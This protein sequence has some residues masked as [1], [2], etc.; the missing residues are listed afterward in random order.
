MPAALVTGSARGIG[1]ALVLE[2]A[3]LGYDV[4]IHYRSSAKEAQE[5]AEQAAKYGVKALPLQADVSSFEEAKGLVI[6]AHNRLGRLDVLVN[7]VG[8]YHKAPLSEVSV[9]NWHAMFDSNLHPVFYTCQTAIPLMRAQGK[10]RI[11]NIGFAG[12][13]HLVARPVITAYGIAKTG[14]ILYSKALAKSEA[15]NNITIN[16]ISPG[17]MEN[18]ETKP[19]ADIPIARTG[20][21]SELTAAVKFLVSDEAA[22]ITGV[23]LEVA[24][25]WNL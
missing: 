21:L 18:S 23:T 2:L 5:V 6:E 16:V 12:A 22:Y 19:I 14:I 7:N 9:E 4:V 24:G 8:N 1:K 11:I 20:H 13:E 15:Q 3:A 10:G 17:V 25:G